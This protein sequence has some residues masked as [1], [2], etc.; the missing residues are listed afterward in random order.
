MK[1]FK[2]A[3]LKDF[4]MLCPELAKYLLKK[5]IDIED[6]NYIVKFNEEYLEIGYASDLWVLK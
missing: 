1:P 2:T 6:E 3:K 5:D 4:L